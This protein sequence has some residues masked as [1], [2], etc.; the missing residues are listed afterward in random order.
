MFKPYKNCDLVHKQQNGNVLIL[1][2]VGIALL[3]ALTYTVFE[4]GNSSDNVDFEKAELM[5]VRIMDQ[6][7][8]YVQ[9]AQRL[10]LAKRYDQILPDSTAT[11]N[12]GTCHFAGVDV[13]PCRT[14]GLFNSANN[15]KLPEVPADAFDQ[16]FSAD[17]D[18]MVWDSRQVLVNGEHVGTTAADEIIILRPLTQAVCEAINWRLE[19][20]DP[21]ATVSYPTEDNLGRGYAYINANGSFDGYYN[22][23]TG[24]AI[25]IPH[26]GC[27]QFA[28]GKMAAF[29]LIEKK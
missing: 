13:T 3:A 19:I 8:T 2:L 21:I 29:F 7:N 28:S 22:N 1:L 6:G 16:T 12:S 24:P 18:I 11:N 14:I 17:P 26:W 20:T 25:D 5:A 27:S 9:A 10:K 23:A 4:S 15:M